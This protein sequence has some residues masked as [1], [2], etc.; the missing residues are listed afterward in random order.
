MKKG[1]TM[2]ELIFVIVI[3]GILAAVAIPR[4]AA[5]R[6]D[7][8]I[9]KALNNI[10]TLVSDVGAYYT[11]QGQFAAN[12]SD[13]TNVQLVTTTGLTSAINAGG[14]PCMTVTLTPDV[15]AT[16]TKGAVPALITVADGTNTT[17]LCAKIQGDP[18]FI[19]LKG[20]TAS[21]VDSVTGSS[22]SVNGIIVS[23]I[24]VVR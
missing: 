1:F 19:R 18:S 2:I 23:G 4:L 11:S 13:M 24:P 21:Y 15:A 5:T 20:A 10:N 12:L 8:E 7:A 22:V 3:L 14:Q 16:S 9:S 6:D 17:G